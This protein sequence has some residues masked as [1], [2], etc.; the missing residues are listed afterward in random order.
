MNK[1]TKLHKKRNS[2]Y[3]RLLT[4]LQI[5]RLN[6]DNTSRKNLYEAQFEVTS[7]YQNAKDTYVVV[8]HL[9]N[10]IRFNTENY[11]ISYDIVQK[12]CCDNIYCLASYYKMNKKGKSNWH[13]LNQVI[14]E[15][16]IDKPQKLLGHKVIARL[17]VTDDDNNAIIIKHERKPKPVGCTFKEYNKEVLL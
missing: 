13:H 8:Y 14:Q 15:L 2:A 4:S 11:S 7:I 10:F 1:K 5:Q 6:K 12:A 9:L 3:S 16:G 17:Y